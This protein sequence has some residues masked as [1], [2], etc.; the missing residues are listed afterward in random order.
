MNNCKCCGK[1]RGITHLRMGFCWDC[2]ELESVIDDGTDMNDN[3][4][5]HY[6]GFS[7]KMDKLKYILTRHSLVQIKPT[8]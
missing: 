2:V 7:T 4:I 5:P 8:N 1:E 6:E 3:P